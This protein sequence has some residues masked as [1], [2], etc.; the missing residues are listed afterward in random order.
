MPAYSCVKGFTLPT[1]STSN[2]HTESCTTKPASPPENT[3]SKPT[4]QKQKIVH[5]PRQAKRMRPYCPSL[6][7]KEKKDNLKNTFYHA[8]FTLLL[9]R[10]NKC[11]GKTD[12]SNSASAANKGPASSV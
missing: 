2:A 12:R 3:T 8:L 10:P 6:L 4:N 7:A 5:P 9:G 1:Q 11:E